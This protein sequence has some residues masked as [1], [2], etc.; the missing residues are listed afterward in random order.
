MQGYMYVK[1]TCNISSYSDSMHEFTQ[2]HISYSFHESHTIY[3]HENTLVK[4][5]L[6]LYN[7]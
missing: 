6:S 7:V 5:L 1:Y 3:L 4:C 2:S